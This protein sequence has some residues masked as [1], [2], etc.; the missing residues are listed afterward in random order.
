MAPNNP[1]F[2]AVSYQVSALFT[3]AAWLAG[4]GAASRSPGRHHY[5][6][7]PNVIPGGAVNHESFKPLTCQLVWKHEGFFVPTCMRV[8]ILPKHPSSLSGKHGHLDVVCLDIP[9][10][11]R[12]S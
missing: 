3:S 8:K 11:R 2:H 7:M 1:T 10:W 12:M 4:P 6:F 5:R 9:K